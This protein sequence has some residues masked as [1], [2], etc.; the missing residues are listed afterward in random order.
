MYHHVSQYLKHLDQII[1]DFALTDV[2]S[3]GIN[4]ELL[5]WKILSLEV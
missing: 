3:F 5:T 4:K 1:Q 2:K